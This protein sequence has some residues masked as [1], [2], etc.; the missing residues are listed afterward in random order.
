MR[1]ITCD[2]TV[3]NI[4]AMWAARNLKFFP[5][6]LK[7][8]LNN[9]ESLANACGIEVPCP[10][11]GSGVLVAMELWQLLNVKVDDV[12]ALPARLQN[13]C[14]ISAEV[15]TTALDEYSV[16]NLGLAEFSQRFLP[17]LQPAVCMVPGTK[18]YSCPKAAAVGLGSSNLINIP[19]NVDARMNVQD[20]R[21]SLQQCLE[22]Q[23]PVV[24]VIAA[25]GSTEESAIDPLHEILALRE[26]FRQQGLEFHRARRRGLGRLLRL[27]APTRPA[28]G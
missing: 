6:A 4:E 18:H 23:R 2:G 28:G 10:D 7:A 19:V 21:A 20:L 26:E 15:L 16:Q 13:D 17:G 5:V 12:L 25:I 24:Q 14:D 3:V 9:E 8:A 27:H 11:G 22:D 1:H